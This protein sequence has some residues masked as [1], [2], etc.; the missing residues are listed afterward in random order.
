MRDERTTVTYLTPT[1]FALLLESSPHA[2]TECQ[3]YRI[4]MFAG[5]RLPARL[6]EAFYDATIPRTVYNT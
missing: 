1:Q 6:A 4:A 3:S 2:L 5:E